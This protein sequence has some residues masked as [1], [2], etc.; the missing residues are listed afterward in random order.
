MWKFI[1]PAAALLLLSG[2]ALAQTGSPSTS[3]SI[4]GSA[5]AGA[6]ASVGAQDS[7]CRAM[8][9]P[10]DRTRCLNNLQLRNRDTTSGGMGGTGG[11]AG[12]SGGAGVG[13]RALDGG[14]SGGISGG[15]GAGSR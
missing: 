4:S 2:G 14:A 12:A 13:G 5:G 1:L 10:D 6:G 7:A 9:N 8:T 11:S 3:P 15:V